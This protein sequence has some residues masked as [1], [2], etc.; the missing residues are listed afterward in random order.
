MASFSEP[1]NQSSGVGNDY[2]RNSLFRK[3]HTYKQNKSKYLKD[4]KI[5]KAI[6]NHIPEG[7]TGFGSMRGYFTYGPQGAIRPDGSRVTSAEGKKLQENIKAIYNNAKSKEAG[8][9]AN[10]ITKA[11]H[12]KL[13]R[14][15]EP[16]GSAY[17]RAMQRFQNAQGNSKNNNK[18]NK[19]K[20]KKGGSKCGCRTRKGGFF[21]RFKKKVNTKKNNKNY[22]NM[23]LSGLESQ[24]KKLLNKFNKIHN[25]QK[26]MVDL[27][28]KS[29]F[30]NNN[31]TANISRQFNNMKNRLG[32]DLQKV[33]KAIAK[34]KGYAGGRR[35][36]RTRK[37]SSG[38]K[39]RRR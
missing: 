10:K 16:G 22:N 21:G 3:H 25:S 30:N 15:A 23:N 13:A 35:R 17:L 33:Q 5:R 24:H 18:K 39:T 11:A 31:K 32:N 36:R 1:V 34:K 2:V 29:A 19:N 9:A 38:R 20:N 6:K 12:K 27:S 14:M 26:Y 4:Y 28:K 7:T 37:R 8:I